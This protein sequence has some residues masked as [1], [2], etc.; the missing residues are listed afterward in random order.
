[1]A[2]GLLVSVAYVNPYEGT[3]SLSDIIL[4]LTGSRGNLELG[5]SMTELLTLIMKLLPYFLFQLYGG[6]QMY[7]QFCTASVYVFSRVP[8]RIRWYIKELFLL[9]KMTLLFLILYMVSVTAVAGLRWNILWTWPGVMMSVYYFLIYGLWLF[10]MTL[11]V[12]LLAAFFGSSSA[13]V[14]VF[15]GQSVMITSLSVLRTFQE[16]TLVFLWLNRINPAARLVFGWQAGD[17]ESIDGLFSTSFYGISL[18]GSAFY[19]LCGAILIACAGG[20]A[21]NQKDLIISDMEN[22][23]V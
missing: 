9:I 4:Q 13:F 20:F 3:I 6:I 14:V 8:D 19:M 22:G 17:F 5:Y 11:A 12:N 18:N 23:G 10:T 15:G 2:G 16:K 7:R 1:M 21:V